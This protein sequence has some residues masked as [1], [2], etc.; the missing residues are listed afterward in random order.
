MFRSNELTIPLE[1][2]LEKMKEAYMAGFRRGCTVYQAV[3]CDEDEGHLPLEQII[4]QQC[5]R[6]AEDFDQGLRDGLCIVP[7]EYD[8]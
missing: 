6:D 3:A 7:S 1:I 5:Q 4:E 8:H 2:F